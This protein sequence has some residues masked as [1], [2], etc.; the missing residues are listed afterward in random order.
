MAGSLFSPIRMI[1]AD[2]IPSWQALIADMEITRVFSSVIRIMILYSIQPT[3]L[4]VW[5]CH[6]SDFFLSLLS[7]RILTVYFHATG[8]TMIIKYEGAGIIVFRKNLE[9]GGTD[10]CII[11][12]QNSTNFGFPKGGMEIGETILDTATRELKEETGLQ[13]GQNVRLFLRQQREPIVEYNQRRK[14]YVAYFVGEFIHT[15]NGVGNKLEWNPKELDGAKW[16]PIPNALSTLLRLRQRV[17]REAY[18][19]WKSTS[20]LPAEL[21]DPRRHQWL[22]KT[23]AWVLRYKMGNQAISITPQ[24]DGWISIETLLTNVPILISKSVSLA[25]IQTVVDADKMHFERRGHMIRV[26]ESCLKWETVTEVPERCWFVTT[27][28]QWSLIQQNGGLQ[29]GQG[30]RYLYFQDAPA[31]TFC[32]SVEVGRALK[33][34]VVPG[35]LQS[36][37]QHPGTLRLCC[38]HQGIGLPF[39]SVRVSDFQ[40]APLSLPQMSGDLDELGKIAERKGLAALC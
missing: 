30:K 3:T 26:C 10:E 18:E 22:S 29:P 25:E 33:T 19:F 17:L 37:N 16:M 36:S 24:Q 38:N 28:R 4:F 7:K 13:V 39:L 5:V 32:V 20:N 31:A 1:I 2:T 9:T 6:L 34:G 11:V 8:K 15:V 40:A 23:L 12:Q 14:I 27:E 35:P 21:S